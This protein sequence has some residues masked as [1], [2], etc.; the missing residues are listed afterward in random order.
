MR[1]PAIEP[2]SV[3]AHPMPRSGGVAMTRPLAIVPGLL[4]QTPPLKSGCASNQAAASLKAAVATAEAAARIIE[5]FLHQLVPT[6]DEVR[7][8]L[9]DDRT[10]TAVG[11]GAAARKLGE[12]AHWMQEMAAQSSLLALR[13]TLNA[14]QFDGP[15]RGVDDRP[16]PAAS[17]LARSI[18]EVAAELRDLNGVSRRTMWPVPSPGAGRR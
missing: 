3:A 10:R 18:V 2:R 13:L 16:R 5:A 11:L 15:D 4:A 6:L 9:A 17:R 12:T 7:H 14:A 8:A 1:R